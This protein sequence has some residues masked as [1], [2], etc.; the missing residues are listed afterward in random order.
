MVIKHRLSTFECYLT[1]S[2]NWTW[3][4]LQARNCWYVEVNWTIANESTQKSNSVCD[5]NLS[6][7]GK[8]VIQE[9]LSDSFQTIQNMCEEQKCQSNQETF[10]VDLLK[11]ILEWDM[12]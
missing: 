9:T 5:Y 3:N 12:E 4:K 10:S 1:K 6:L 11:Q 2:R 8:I 7:L